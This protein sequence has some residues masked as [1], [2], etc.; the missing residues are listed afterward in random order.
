MCE[1]VNQRIFPQMIG[2]STSAFVPEMSIVEVES[3]RMPPMNSLFVPDMSTAVTPVF[4]TM[5]RMLSLFGSHSAE[6]FAKAHW[7]V[8]ADGDAGHPARNDEFT[9]FRTNVPLT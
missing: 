9:P 7:C 6:T 1:F 5:K 3:Q 4:L 8:G 2:P